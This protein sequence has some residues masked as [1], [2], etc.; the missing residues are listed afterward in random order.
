[1]EKP[2]I[3]GVTLKIISTPQQIL[4]MALKQMYP[5]I[6]GK[7]KKSAPGILRDIKSLFKS[8]IVGSET[9][10][11]LTSGGI[12]DRALRG[13][14]G[15]PAGQEHEIVDPIV[16]AFINSLH[17]DFSEFSSNSGHFRILGVPSDYF[18]VISLPTAKIKNDGQAGGEIPWLLWLLTAGS[19]VMVNAQIV[20]NDYTSKVFSED[21]NK[22]NGGAYSR[23]KIALMY[24]RHGATWAVPA[25]FSG[26][27]N[28]NWITR[29]IDQMEA[30][31]E[32]DNIFGRYLGG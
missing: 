18:N 25:E 11:S 16:D 3:L 9:Y 12:S 17:Y 29:I 27:E 21:S 6:N 14:F 8:L 28:D 20:F 31:K 30:S 26:T 1:M 19:E 13:H 4:D 7:I 2:D 22:I 24:T 10:H 32:V 15:F 5:Q 23:S